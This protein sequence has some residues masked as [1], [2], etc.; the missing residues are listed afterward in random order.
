MFYKADN[1]T[2]I[3]KV[4][5]GDESSVWFNAVIRGDI[6]AIKIGKNTNIQDNVVIHTDGGIVVSIG[7]MFPL[8]IAPF[9]MAAKSAIIA[10]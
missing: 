2:V 8:V 9:C 5:I 6:E 3:G 1:S 10:L 7:I 4:E